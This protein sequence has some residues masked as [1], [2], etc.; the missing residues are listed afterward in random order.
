M[1]FAYV[2]DG[3]SALPELLDLVAMSLLWM[4]HAH[5]RRPRSRAR[6]SDD[7][8]EPVPAPV[9]ALLDL[10]AALAALSA[11]DVTHRAAT[12]RIRA[13][14]ALEQARTLGIAAVGRPD[15]AY[16][17]ALAIIGDP[18]PVLWVCGSLDPA[19]PAVAV[20][21]SRAATPHGLDMAFELARDLA[22]AGVVVVSG[23]ARGIDSA[24]H[25]GALRGEGPTLAVMGSGP[26]V[27]YP[28][29]HA[30]LAAQIAALGAVLS[31]LPPGAPPRSWH[32]PRRNRI[33]AGLSSA[34][35]VVEAAIGSGSL[36]TAG[37]ALEQNRAVMAVPGGVLGGHNRGAHGL[38]R[39]GARIVESVQDVLEELQLDGSGLAG[40]GEA[41]PNDPVLAAMVPGEQYDLGGLCLSCG[42][43]AARTLAH[44]A[45]L[46]LT[47][48]ISRAG[49]GRF[50]RS[51]AN[52]LR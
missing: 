42:L 14:A 20:V 24:A 39:D 18:P 33:I 37:C 30:D 11:K 28:P 35:V 3:V 43:D 8:S 7:G 38:L 32:F 17:P 31:E 12:L 13:A 26:N 2:R 40:A 19:S 23:L 4:D 6:T 22:R 9:E 21:G 29:E 46:E 45:E 36:I 1:D 41:P 48:W 49:G 15:A 51:R 5:R 52:V 16:P 27:I 10:E 50:V 44:L 25:R 47:G 34:V